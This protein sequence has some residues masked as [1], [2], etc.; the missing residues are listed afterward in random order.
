VKYEVIP[1]VCAGPF[2]FGMTVD[3][4][5]GSLGPATSRTRTISGA[6]RVRYP[7]L[8]LVF[9][10]AAGLVEVSFTPQEQLIV[11]GIDVF[12]ELAPLRRL[13]QVDPSPLESVGI[14]Y[15]PKLGITL[16]GFHKD[17]SRTVTVMAA[18]RLESLQL[19][20]SFKPYKVE[21]G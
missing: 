10:E 3:E 5:V 12:H 4:A 8:D 7:T 1:H 18:G 21:R 16:S 6:L 15:F 2:R 17:D 20:P 19:M 11:A 13:A 9:T 14:L